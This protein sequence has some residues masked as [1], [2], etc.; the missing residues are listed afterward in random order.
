LLTEEEARH[1]ELT[2]QLKESNL[3]LE[4]ISWIS[5][6]D[7]KEPLRKIQLFSSRLLDL[8]KNMSP[9]ISHTLQKMNASANK[10]QKLI[11]D[12]TNYSKIR[13]S[14]KSFET[15]NLQELVEKVKKELNEEIAEKNASIQTHG[16]SEVKGIPVIVHQLFS[17]LIGNALKFSKEDFPAIIEISQ[18]EAPIASPE[19]GDNKLYTRIIVADN[20][21]GFENEFS[22]KIFK[23]F[24]RLHAP[25]KYDGTGIGLALSKKIMQLH[26]GYIFA[27]SAKGQGATF[28]LYFPI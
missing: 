22:D 7:L 16:L 26:N 24:T 6:H 21:I 27:E 11:S 25:D 10:M 4:N 19:P 5:T 12:I 23:I 20:G 13:H 9:E 1:R 8:E 28:S 18:S 3:E 15:I 2:R 17:N 14:E